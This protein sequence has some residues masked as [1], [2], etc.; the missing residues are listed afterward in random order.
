MRQVDETNLRPT[1]PRLSFLDADVLCTLYASIGTLVPVSLLFHL[2]L[3]K[4]SPLTGGCSEGLDAF[5][6]F[7]K[8]RIS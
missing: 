6:V 5:R 1:G 7:F 8:L 4:F 2:N 3:L